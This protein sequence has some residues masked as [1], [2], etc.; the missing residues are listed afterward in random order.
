VAVAT[1]FILK[2][3]HPRVEGN[4]VGASSNLGL[5]PNTIQDRLGSK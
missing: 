2:E 5:R 1:E 4:Q 3:G